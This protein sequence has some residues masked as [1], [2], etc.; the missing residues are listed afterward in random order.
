MNFKQQYLNGLC[1]LDHIEACIGQWHELPE[2]G[3]SLMDY[4]GLTQEEYDVFLQTDPSVTLQELLDSQRRRQ[5]FRIYQLNLEDG[6]TIPFAF[7]GIDRLHKEG[8]QQPPASMYQ[9]SY[10]GELLCAADRQANDVLERVFQQY[11]NDL[12]KDYSGRSVSPSDVVEL[13]D[14]ERREY[15][16]RD[17]DSFVPVK[18]SPMLVRTARKMGPQDAPKQPERTCQVCKRCGGLRIYEVEFRTD[19]AMPRIFEPVNE[20]TPALPQEDIPYRISGTYC[21]DCQSFC[22]TETRKADSE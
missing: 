14:N 8:Y 4:L 16:Y 17:T 9:L 7:S 21:M 19:Y 2:D 12:P 5:R 15:F 10:D 22:D 18:F 20:G 1:T 11:N 6:R 3:V 13:Y